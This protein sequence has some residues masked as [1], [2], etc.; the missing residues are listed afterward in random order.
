MKNL[1]YRLG[2]GISSREH[3]GGLHNLLDR[4]ESRKVPLL[5]HPLQDRQEEGIVHL[6]LDQVANLLLLAGD[7]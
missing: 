1:D 7:T 2:N 5:H 6:L 3:M 4:G